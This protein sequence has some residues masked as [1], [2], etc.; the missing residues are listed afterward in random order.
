M[1]ITVNNPDLDGLLVRDLRLPEDVLFL[2]VARNGQAIVPSGYTP[3][4]LMDEVTLLGQPESL[5][6]VTLKMGY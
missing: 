6:E 4:K 2:E 3:L 5:S 1:Q